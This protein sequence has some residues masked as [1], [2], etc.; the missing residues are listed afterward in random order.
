MRTLEGRSMTS[1]LA[2][3]LPVDVCRLLFAHP[4]IAIRGMSPS[5]LRVERARERAA[6]LPR[7]RQTP[8]GCG[9]PLA[10]RN[11]QKRGIICRNRPIPRQLLLLARQSL[12]AHRSRPRGLR[13]R[14]P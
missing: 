4:V 14:R 6:L 3:S 11:G 2:I 10:C 7:P 5:I 8:S 13:R 1:T 9:R 12:V